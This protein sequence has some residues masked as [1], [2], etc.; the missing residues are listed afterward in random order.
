MIYMIY[1]LI[2]P[3]AFW[4]AFMIHG[5][6]QSTPTDTTIPKILFFDFIYS[7]VFPPPWTPISTEAAIKQHKDIHIP[8]LYKIWYVP[9]INPF[10]ALRGTTKPLSLF[11][12]AS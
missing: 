3:N 8:H 12:N 2:P 11:R 1:I 7:C 6:A 4:T 9:V 5:T 10:S